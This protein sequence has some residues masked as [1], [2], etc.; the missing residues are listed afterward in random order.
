TVQNEAEERRA[1]ENGWHPTQGAALEALEARD[2]AVSDITAARHYGD[3]RMSE[4]ARREAAL[5]D[6]STLKHVP[7]VTP[8]AVKEARSRRKR[9]S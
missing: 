5:V 1:L 4:P 6:Q 2:N 9:A 3:A 8:A 7:E